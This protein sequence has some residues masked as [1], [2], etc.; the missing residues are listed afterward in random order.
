MSSTKL[1]QRN[2]WSLG[3]FLSAYDLFANHRPV[4]NDFILND[5][6]WRHMSFDIL[7]ILTPLIRAN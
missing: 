6:S 2:H 5:F 3:D 4:L 7:L 1:T